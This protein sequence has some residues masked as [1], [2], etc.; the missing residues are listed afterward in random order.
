MNNLQGLTEKYLHDCEH[1]KK[2]S[3]KTIKAYRIDLHQFYLFCTGKEDPFSKLSI[4]NYIEGLHTQYKPKTTKRKIACLRAFINYLAFEEIIESNPLDKVRMNFKEPL[5][6]PRALPLKSI[7]KLLCAAHKANA[8]GKSEHAHRGI[9]RDIAVLELLFASGLRVSELCSIQR[10]DIDLREGYVKVNGKGARERF[11]YISNTEVLDA[12]RQYKKLFQ[13]TIDEIG[14]FFVNRLG[15][16]LCEQSVRT[17]IHNY[18]C[19]A[20]INR[21]VTPHMIRHS[22]ATLMLEEDVDIRYIQS[23][24]GHSSIT[25]TQI[26][27]HVS[28]SK[29]RKIMLRKH[30][31]NRLQM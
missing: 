29:Q 17:I 22:F 15:K 13:K 25:T 1:R 10:V 24:L 19:L 26:Y 28:T 12:L 4:T 5:V 27:T 20:K 21:H 30:P 7:Q 3:D 16:R 31:R 6:L 18:A 23:I 11:V 9:I 14:W 2:L 8:V